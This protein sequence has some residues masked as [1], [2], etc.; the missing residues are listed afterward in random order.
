MFLIFVCFLLVDLFV[1]LFVFNHP[2][3]NHSRRPQ[4]SP[5]TQVVVLRAAREAYLMLAGS[6]LC[7]TLE[8]ADFWCMPALWKNAGVGG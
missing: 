4:P 2:F 5:H 1:C 6:G 3:F 8:G 7:G